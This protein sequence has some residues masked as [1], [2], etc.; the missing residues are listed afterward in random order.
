MDS[1]LDLPDKI[2]QIFS[3]FP[4]FIGDVLIGLFTLG[5]LY[6]LKKIFF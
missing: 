3:S 6:L 5:L 4:T 2:A 1:L